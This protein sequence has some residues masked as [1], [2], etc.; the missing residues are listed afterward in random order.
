MIPSVCL[1]FAA[2]AWVG[3]AGISLLEGQ[4][5]AALA[6]PPESPPGAVVKLVRAGWECFSDTLY[7]TGLLVPKQEAAVFLDERSRVTEVL[8]GAG[9]QVKAGQVLARAVR[10]F[11]ET[12]PAAGSSALAKAANNAIAMR[13]PAA[14]TV[15]QTAASIG[16]GPSP[17][18]QPLFRIIVANEIELEADVPA[19]QVP[20]LKSGQP[21]RIKLENGIELIGQLRRPPAQIDRATQLG[22]ARL[23][24]AQDPSLRTG[25]FAEAT[26]DA[27]QSCGVA[28]PRD[29]V[30][31]SSEGTSVQVV[32]NNIVETKRVQLGLSS[33]DSFEINDGI[34]KGDIVVAHAGSS[35]HDGDPVQPILTDG[36]DD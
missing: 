14:G 1:G 16:A 3:L 28:V 17:T 6:A 13:A 7:V 35:L 15:M 10:L 23:S 25:M 8:A 34:E 9:D 11:A 22:R 2:G 4:P 21:A 33:A 24:V 12:T 31:R 29:A 27:S 36:T 5:G 30:L 20:K 32:R 19:S 18:G 26:I